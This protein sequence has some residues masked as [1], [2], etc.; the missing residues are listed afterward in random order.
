MKNELLASYVKLRVSASSAAFKAQT[1]SSLARFRILVREV[2][3]A[4]C[5]IGLSQQ[6]LANPALSSST[7]TSAT[8]ELPIACKV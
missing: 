7:D 8:W 6:Y 5:G 1:S 4:P 3:L 2:R